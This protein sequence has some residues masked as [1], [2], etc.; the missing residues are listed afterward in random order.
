MPLG[1]ISG[2]S[3]VGMGATVGGGSVGGIS[4]GV[5]VSVVGWVV[6]AGNVAVAGWRVG[7]VTDGKGMGV[8]VL[9]SSGVEGVGDTLVVNWQANVNNSNEANRK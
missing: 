1:D 6:D 5:S 3:S 8:F 7:A 9:E 2:G 4:V